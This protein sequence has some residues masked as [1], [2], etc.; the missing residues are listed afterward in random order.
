MAGNQ[1]CQAACIINDCD[2]YQRFRRNLLRELHPLL[3]FMAD[4]ASQC[5]HL[6]R[7]VDLILKFFNLDLIIVLQC[8]KLLDDSA[9]Q[10]LDQHPDGTAR[11]LQQ[12]AYFCN[13]AHVIQVLKIRLI[14]FCVLL[15]HQHDQSIIDHCLLQGS[16]G[17][18]PPYIQMDNHIGK[19]RH[20][21]QR[22]QWNCS[23]FRHLSRPQSIYAFSEKQGDAEGSALFFM[24]HAEASLPPLA[25]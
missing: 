21:S 12:L 7:A 2:G 18:L 8:T 6:H 22:Q 3:K 25:D 24:P 15:C 11:H 10:S 23:C 19:D 1:I 20:P 4:T 13:C 17:A 14:Y 16:Y 5:L 9:V